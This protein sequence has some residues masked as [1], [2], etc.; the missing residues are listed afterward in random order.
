[1]TV[2]ED[3]LT[4]NKYQEEFVTAEHGF[5]Y[6]GHTLYFQAA[7]VKVEYDLAQRQLLSLAFSARITETAEAL[8]LRQ[9]LKPSGYP[10]IREVSALLN[11]PHV[12]FWVH[13]L[14]PESLRVQ[15]QNTPFFDTQDVRDLFVA[16]TGVTVFNQLNHYELEK[17]SVNSQ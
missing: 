10:D 7:R 12:E 14:A 17:I 16:E 8:K 11:T 4:G 3:L 9:L 13:W 5:Q 2:F 1:M 15:A 6:Q